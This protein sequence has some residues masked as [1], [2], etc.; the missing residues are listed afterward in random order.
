MGDGGAR[1]WTFAI[2]GLIR[3]EHSRIVVV[4]QEEL[5]RESNRRVRE[6]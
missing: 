6:K 2:G 5:E 1:L 4:D 3:R